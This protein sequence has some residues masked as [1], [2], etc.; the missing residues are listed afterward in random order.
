MRR[1]FIRFICV[2]DVVMWQ[3][4]SWCYE[5]GDTIGI[6]CPNDVSEVKSLLSL[7]GLSEMADVVC[8]LEVLSDTRKRNAAVP[9]HLPV[10]STLFNL[11]HTCCEIRHIPRKV[12]HT[13]GLCFSGLLFWSYLRLGHIPQ[14]VAF[15][16]NWSRVFWATVCKTVRPV[17]S[18]CCL[19]VCL[20]VTFVHCGQTVGWIKMKL[21]M[22]VGL[23][24]VTLC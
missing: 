12:D 8:S 16:D 23:P 10:K 3:A 17:L 13:H 19:S 21:G 9:E 11:L 24:L 22:Q 18:V 6:V 5:P 20:S 1:H 4:C 14:S 2:G 7:L 15:R